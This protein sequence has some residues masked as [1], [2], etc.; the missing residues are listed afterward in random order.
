MEEKFE[1]FLHNNPEVLLAEAAEK[2]KSLNPHITDDAVIQLHG[3]SLGAYAPRLI[4]I[5]HSSV[6]PI[7]KNICQ[8]PAEK[9]RSLGRP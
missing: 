3:H 7:H 9:S 8:H 4:G 6:L 1:D 2:F 5:G